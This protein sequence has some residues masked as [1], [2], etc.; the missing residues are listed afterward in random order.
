MLLKKEGKKGKTRRLVSLYKQKKYPFLVALP[1]KQGREA[2][3]LQGKG[4]Y[5]TLF[6]KLLPLKYQEDLYWILSFFVPK[7]RKRRDTTHFF[8]TLLK[9]E[10]KT[11]RF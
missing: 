9:K 7:K 10:G 5:I 4:H 1:S 11:R 3:S 2:S 6:E 8:C